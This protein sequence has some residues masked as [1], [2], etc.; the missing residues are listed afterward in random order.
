MKRLLRQFSTNPPLPH[1]LS[2]RSMTGPAHQPC[3]MTNPLAG[4][5][6]QAPPSCKPQVQMKI[7]PVAKHKPAQTSHPLEGPVVTQLWAKSKSLQNI[8]LYPSKLTS[9]CTTKGPIT[10]PTNGIPTQASRQYTGDTSKHQT[11]TPLAWQCSTPSH[12]NHL[13]CQH[14]ACLPCHSF[15]TQIHTM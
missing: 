5:T 11:Y 3:T 13:V 6:H 7:S 15:V 1:P 8:I 2:S 9:E 14:C 12:D 4:T 10:P